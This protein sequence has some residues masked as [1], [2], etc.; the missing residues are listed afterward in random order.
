MISF[1]ESKCDNGL[2]EVGSELH[3]PPG[4]GGGGGDDE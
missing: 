4:F 3:F 1:T 2:G